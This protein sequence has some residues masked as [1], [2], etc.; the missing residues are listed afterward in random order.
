MAISKVWIEEG[1]TA[2][3]LCVD[4]CPEVFEMADDTAVVIE[5]AKVDVFEDQ[6]IEAADSC[7]VEVIRYE[8]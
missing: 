8:A 1:C 7:P 4:I 5:N 2:C 3:E 6:V